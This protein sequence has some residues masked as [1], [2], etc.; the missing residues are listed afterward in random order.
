MHF[1]L[2]TY[3][4]DK[5]LGVVNQVP[6]PRRFGSVPATAYQRL[7][8]QKMDVGRPLARPIKVL[9]FDCGSEP[10]FLDNLTSYEVAHRKRT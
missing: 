1:Q 9:E 5:P 7:A 3:S 6:Q 2:A 4:T 10:D 8:F